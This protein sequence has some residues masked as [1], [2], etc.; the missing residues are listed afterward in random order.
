MPSFKY[1][2]EVFVKK[3]ILPLVRISKRMSQFSDLCTNYYIRSIVEE[4]V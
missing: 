1:R 3:T 4:N 2:L